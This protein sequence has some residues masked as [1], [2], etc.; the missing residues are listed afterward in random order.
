MFGSTMLEVAIGMAFIYTALSLV[1]TAAR[2]AIES[3]THSRSADLERGIR[4]LL[5]SPE[6]RGGAGRWLAETLKGHSIDLGLGPSV[7]RRSWWRKSA[8]TS[9][10]S[11]PAS[12]SAGDAGTAAPTEAAATPAVAALK[13][14]YQHPLIASLYAGNRGPTYIPTRHFVAAVLDLA[15]QTPAGGGVASLEDFKAKLRAS[16]VLP[17]QVKNA[18][19]A[20]ATQAHGDMDKFK[21]SVGDW[22]DG[23]M[24][25]VSGWY[26]RRTQAMLFALGFGVAIAANA[27]TIRMADQLAR[28]Q[29]LRSAFAGAAQQYAALPATQTTSAPSEVRA[30]IAQATGNLQSLGL[31]LGWRDCA[32]EDWSPAKAHSLDP[33]CSPG[34]LLAY[35]QMEPKIGFQEWLGRWW[36]QFSTHFFGWL[37]TAFALTLGA[38]FWFDVLNKIMVIRST[39][40][41]REKSPEEASEDRQSAGATQTVRVVVD[42]AP[43]TAG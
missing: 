17:D 23:T 4:Q 3:W 35:M 29:T 2:E 42:G 16:T 31:P 22:F 10:P 12:G 40:K 11:I 37:V 41:P 43:G 13:D 27:D 18:L 7:E 30:A 36:R 21:A 1:C 19:G 5:A 39:V 15:A 9:T 32:A 34:S 38:P 25:R 24:D 14:F 33:R 20:L 8:A 26:K 28:D 6:R